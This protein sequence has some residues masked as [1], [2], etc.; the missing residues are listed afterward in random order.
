DASEL[1][2]A[3]TRLEDRIVPESEAG[4]GRSSKSETKK[5]RRVRG[6]EVAAEESDDS[7]N[8]RISYLEEVKRRHTRSDGSSVDAGKGDNSL[9][10]IERQAKLTANESAPNVAESDE[11]EEAVTFA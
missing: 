2:A 4:R 8:E 5:S 6:E 9:T 3:L 7:R 1:L 11:G 10:G